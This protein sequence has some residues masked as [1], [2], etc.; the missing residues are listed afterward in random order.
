[1]PLWDAHDLVCAHVWFSASSIP[2][3]ASSFVPGA[4]SEAAEMETVIVTAAEASGENRAGGR[5]LRTDTR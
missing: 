3:A 5:H 1:M 4:D 2:H